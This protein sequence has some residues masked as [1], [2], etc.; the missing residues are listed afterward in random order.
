MT[1]FSGDW[2]R[3]TLTLTLPDAQGTLHLAAGL[4]PADAAAVTLYWHAAHLIGID[5]VPADT[6]VTRTLTIIPPVTL[7]PAYLARLIAEQADSAKLKLV[8]APTDALPA[9]HRASAL[10]YW[11]TLTPLLTLLGMTLAPQKRPAKAQHRWRAAVAKVPFTTTFGGS[12]ATVYWAKRNELV[13]KAGAKLK[14]Q[15]DLNA[16]GSLGFAARFA[17][18]LRQEHAASISADF[19]TTEDV[20]LKSVNEVG[21]FLYFANTNSWLQLTDPEG[22]TIDAWTVVK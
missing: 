10:A 3:D 1:P 14:P 4:V 19:T 21:H 5:G 12:Q 16:D 22:K 6:P 9:N 20:T 2:I 7:E 11:T 17:Q 13:I 8:Q 15:A 18:Q